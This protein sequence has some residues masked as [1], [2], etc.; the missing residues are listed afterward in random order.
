MIATLADVFLSHRR[1]IMWSVMRIVRDRQTAEDVTQETYLRAQRAAEHAP[2]DHVEA[3]LFQTAR[4]L[5]LNHR[6]RQT[7]RGRI[8]RDGVP[9]VDVANVASG[10]PSQEAGLIHRQRLHCI[11]ETVSKL[12]PRARTA[13]LLSR[14]EKWPYP[15]IAEHL[16]VSPNTVF[17][18]LKRAHAEC[19][20]ALAKIDRD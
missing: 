11:A 12:P 6:R 15:K 1:S 20:A 16:G 3:F 10:V 4:N 18:D 19:I 2:I 5:A 17:N 13:W 7:M 9:D 14:I 8:E